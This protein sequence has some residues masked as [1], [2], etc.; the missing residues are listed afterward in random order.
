MEKENLLAGRISTRKCPT[1]GHHEVGYVTE[2]G[3]FHSLKP[4]DTI[5]IVQGESTPV[6]ASAGVLTAKAEPMETEQADQE[7]L[8]AWIPDPMKHDKKLRMKYGVRI[9]ARWIQDNMTG[10]I[11]E[12]AFRQKLQRLIEK[13]IYVPLPVIF[14]RYFNSPHLAAGNSKDIADAIFEELDEIKEPVS[15]MRAWLDDPNE[16]NLK[17][18]MPIETLEDS[19]LMASC[20]DEEFKQELDALTLEDF[21]ELL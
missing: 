14:D 20:S 4:G 2:D 12:L 3:G 7:A 18:L 10:G 17:R 13:E 1:C 16:D 11:Y 8:I 15:R 21:F 9:G 19:S 6:D 5:K